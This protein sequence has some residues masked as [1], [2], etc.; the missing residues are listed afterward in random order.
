VQLHG[1][2]IAASSPG[3]GRGA[4]FTVTLPVMH[5]VR[6][7]EMEVVVEVR[8]EG[9]PG[10]SEKEQDANQLQNAATSPQG[11]AVQTVLVVDDAASNR[12]MLCR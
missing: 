6:R 12:K 8:E 11:L 5:C 9:D 7:C 3:L 10:L 2:L 4:T 1:G